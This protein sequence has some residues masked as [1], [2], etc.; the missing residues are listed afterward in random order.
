MCN[1]LGTAPG[2]SDLCSCYFVGLFGI[3]K[4]PVLDGGMRRK[5]VS[6]TGKRFD[7]SALL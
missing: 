5:I 2:T 7:E 1:S 4:F 3:N 6:Q